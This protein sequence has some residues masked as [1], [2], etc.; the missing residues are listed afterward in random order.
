MTKRKTV[1][2]VLFATLF[3]AALPVWYIAYSFYP[4]QT[5]TPN[6]ESKIMITLARRGGVKSEQTMVVDDPE[7]AAFLFELF[8]KQY[9]AEFD[10][11][12]CPFDWC[13][14]SFV[15]GRGTIVFYPAM[16]GCGFV[17]YRGRF[18]YITPEEIGKLKYICQKYY[19]KQ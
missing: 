19:A 13:W 18:F 5:R 16:D 8:G 9:T 17:R 10:S 3:L 1:M 4:V 7:D 14:I 12:S 6:A 2:I 15:H 11:P